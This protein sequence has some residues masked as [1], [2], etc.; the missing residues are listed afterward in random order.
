M[1]IGTLSKS[2]VRRISAALRAA[3]K[4]LPRRGYCASFRLSPG[5]QIR[6]VNVGDPY[7]AEVC[8][9]RSGYYLVRSTVAF[10]RHKHRR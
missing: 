2:E 7:A 8:R 3:G 4:K 10:G 1:A 6:L 9:D 5:S